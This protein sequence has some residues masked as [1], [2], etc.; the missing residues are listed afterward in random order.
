MFNGEPM[1]GPGMSKLSKKISQIISDTDQQFENH[2]SLFEYGTQKDIERSR[3]KFIDE[4]GGEVLFFEDDSWKKDLLKPEFDPRQNPTLERDV[5]KLLG[6]STT[7]I[8]ATTKENNELMYQ[9]YDKLVQ[10]LSDDKPGLDGSVDRLMAHLNKRI[11]EKGI[12]ERRTEDL[13]QTRKLLDE[14]KLIMDQILDP[15]KSFE[16]FDFGLDE[17]ED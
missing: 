14:E 5:K 3:Q 8:R 4:M 6:G 15:S 1:S 13:K 17:K 16:D 11:D 12:H 10:Y 7:T 9:H 2:L